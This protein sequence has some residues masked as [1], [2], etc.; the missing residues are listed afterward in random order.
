MKYVRITSHYPCN[1]CER[2]TYGIGLTDDT[3]D[4]P[5]L[6]ETICDLSQNKTAVD[7]LIELCNALQ[8]DPIHLRDVAE[9]F[10]SVS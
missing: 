1:G 9:D 7:R 8:L 2:V 3:S 6:L 4:E 5:I 10:L